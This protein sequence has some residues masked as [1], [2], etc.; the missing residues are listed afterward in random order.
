MRKAN[1]RRVP[2]A[3]IEGVSAERIARLDQ[4]P[5]EVLTVGS[6]EGESFA[7]EVVARVEAMP[8]R[9]AIQLLSNEL[10]RR[11]GLLDA[12]GLVRLG[13]FASCSIALR[14]TSS[15]NTSITTSARPNATIYTVTWA[16]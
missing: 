2:N 7:A 1:G 13:P 6:I 4:E 16:L 15:S 14:T 5:R 12:Q 8:E 3:R 9:E 10:E 11:H